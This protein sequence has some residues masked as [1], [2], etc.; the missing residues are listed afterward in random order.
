MPHTRISSMTTQAHLK[1][2]HH[3][4]VEAVL[5]HTH[6]SRA[7]HKRIS[8][9]NITVT[10]QLE[11]FLINFCIYSSCAAVFWCRW[12]VSVALWLPSCCRVSSQHYLAYWEAHK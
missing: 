6:A 5:R 9:C 2:Q 10:L 12:C 8:R 4:D 11:H 3:S 1:M 7:S